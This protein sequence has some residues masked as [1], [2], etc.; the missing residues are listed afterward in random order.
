MD[1]MELGAIGELV[2]GIAVIGSL[3]FVGLQVRQNNRLVTDS[4]VQAARSITDEFLRDLS[5]DPLLSKFYLAG[6]A[7]TDALP[8]EERIRFDMILLRVFRAM[9]SLFLEHRDRLMSDEVW[10]SNERT[11]MRI[12]RQ[13][14]GLAS[15]QRQSPLFVERFVGYVDE[16][17]AH[18]QAAKEA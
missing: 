18:A 15:W 14:G 5:K 10:R 2:G 8:P 1:I 3:I 4:V 17:A 16:V 6:L 7:D 12:L 11:F 9:E 13:P